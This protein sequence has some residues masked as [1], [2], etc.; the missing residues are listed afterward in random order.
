M[1]RHGLPRDGHRE[2]PVDDDGLAVGRDDRIIL[3]SRLLCRMADSGQAGAVFV[4][5]VADRRRTGG[6][7]PS[8]KF[9]ARHLLCLIRGNSHHLSVLHAAVLGFRS[10]PRGVL[11]M[12]WM[13][14]DRIAL[15]MA[16]IHAR[17]RRTH[18]SCGVL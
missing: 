3:Q 8:S 2:W 18:L 11:C 5:S 16:E 13:Q 4:Q 12:D 14:M 7:L 15:L 9:S 1:R 10:T 6:N 17:T